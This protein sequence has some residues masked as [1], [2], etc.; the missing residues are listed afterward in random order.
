[1]PL[2]VT[3]I[4]EA[5]NG[6]VYAAE[7]IC[8]SKLLLGPDIPTD[9][10]L[11]SSTVSTIAQGALLQAKRSSLQLRYRPRGERTQING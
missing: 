7:L 8:L 11:S 6:V 10:G 2:T 9:I 3:Q 4:T 5:V 1:M